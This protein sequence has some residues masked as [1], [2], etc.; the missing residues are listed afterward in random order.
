MAKEKDDVRRDEK[1]AR[2]NSV[3]QAIT[4]DQNL[5]AQHLAAATERTVAIR[6]IADSTQMLVFAQL[7]AQF[8]D[9]AARAIQTINQLRA[10]V[11]P[12]PPALA[13][14]AQLAAGGPPPAGAPPPADNV[15]DH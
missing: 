4:D 7:F 11:L 14:L 3:L 5:R 2:Q 1:K 13:A 6:Q 8:G 15:G 10:P 9:N 12:A